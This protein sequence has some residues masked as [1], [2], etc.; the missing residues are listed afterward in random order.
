MKNNL[1]KIVICMV[2]L[3]CVLCTFGKVQK[4]NAAESGYVNLKIGE[5]RDNSKTFKKYDVT[6]DGEADKVKISI[7]TV[8]ES[9][10]DLRLQI[11]VNDNIAYDVVSED[12]C[13]Y[14]MGLVF[15]KNGKVFF[16]ILSTISSE[17]MEYHGLYEYKDGKIKCIYDFLKYYSKYTHYYD[18][19]IYKVKGNS[20]YGS[21]FVQFLSLGGFKSYNIKFVYKDGKIKRASNYYPIQYESAKDNKWTVNRKIKV[22]KK[23]GDKNIIYTL[24]KGDI[25]KIY[26]VVYKNKK[27]YFQIKDKNGKGKIGYIQAISNFP[28]KVYFKETQYSG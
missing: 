9:E 10:Y 5:L 17:D 15:L 25:I 19:N 2:A 12:H 13:Y 16:D 1:K 20:I 28:K 23:P 24:K 3:L 8:G 22:Y 26:K 27:V 14:S 6:G 11:Y 4:V 18:V 7:T 21:T